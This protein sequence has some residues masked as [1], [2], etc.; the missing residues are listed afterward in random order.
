MGVVEDGEVVASAT[1]GLSLA[2]TAVLLWA[3]C[4][5]GGGASAAAGKQHGA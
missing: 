2:G 3:T 1:I 5:S 4:R